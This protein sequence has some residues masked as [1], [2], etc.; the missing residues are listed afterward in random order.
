MKQCKKCG[1]IYQ[2]SQKFCGECGSNL[3]KRFTYICNHC[4][5]I[6]NDDSVECPK[7]HAKP[8]IQL[9]VSSTVKAQ[10]IQEAATQ[11]AGEVKEKAAIAATAAAGVAASFLK[12]ASEKTSEAGQKA[13]DFAKTA[14]EKASKI[15]TEAKEK[16]NDTVQNASGTFTQERASSNKKMLMAMIAVVLVIGCIGGYFLLGRSSDNKNNL[17]QSTLPSAADSTQKSKPVEK[18]TEKAPQFVVKQ[19]TPRD[20]FISFHGAITNKQLSEAYNILTPKYQKFMR[21]YDNFAHGYATTIQ[22]HVI[23]L[24]SISEDNN[25]AILTYKLKAEDRADSGNVIQYFI[26]KAKLSKISGKWFIESTE[27]RKAS[28]N[29]K[30]PVNFA[31]ITAKGEVNL[32][33]YPST[34]ANSIGVVREGDLV[35][36]LETGTC[37]DSSAA[38]VISDDIYF[39]S[40]SKRTQLSKG[41][42]IQIV[43]DN[44][45]K[46][47]CRVNVNGRPENVNFAPNHLV[48]LYGTTWYK[49]SGNG[50]TGWIYSNY[51]SKR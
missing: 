26:G 39:G 1:I 33:A 2:D 43:K 42:A 13:A 45:S 15:T 49:V 20:A 29:S 25:T 46:I 31:S 18:K 51:I 34:N 35:E 17:A 21:S 11:K 3:E 14:S 12:T 32:R 27:A 8:D 16:V 44:G 5:R 19:G 36:I 4:G 50:Y 22:S 40:G 9:L 10:E 23:E 6:Y 48:K 30:A 7:C 24:N 28:Q 37:S 38:I 41:M 47:V